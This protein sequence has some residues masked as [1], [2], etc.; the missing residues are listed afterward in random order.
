MELKVLPKR[1]V[2]RE[3]SK[4][5]QRIRPNL[6]SKVNRSKKISKRN[7]LSLTRENEYFKMNMKLRKIVRCKNKMKNVGDFTNIIKSLISPKSKAKQ[8]LTPSIKSRRDEKR[9][10]FSAK[11]PR[12]NESEK[13][14][15]IELST[16][17]FYKKMAYRIS[18]KLEQN[19]I[20]NGRFCSPVILRQ[21]ATDFQSN[22]SSSKSI[23]D[24]FS[25]IQ[26]AL[27]KIETEKFCVK[28]N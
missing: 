2:N 14:K 5:T 10:V 7:V 21:K 16:I 13:K 23:N 3:Q 1:A 20:V 22:G 28:L 17:E 19:K 15:Q 26:S 8:I 6:R 4:L 25:L 11:R 24:E 27:P 9:R 12:T 18:R